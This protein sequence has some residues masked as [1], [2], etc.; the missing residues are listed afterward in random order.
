MIKREND[1]NSTMTAVFA[2]MENFKLTDC[3]H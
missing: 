1:P 3:T 2:F